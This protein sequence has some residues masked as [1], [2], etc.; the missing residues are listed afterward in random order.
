MKFGRIELSHVLT[1]NLTPRVKYYVCNKQKRKFLQS[2]ICRFTHS[3]RIHNVDN[4]YFDDLCFY[5]L[6]SYEVTP[7]SNIRISLYHFNASSYD[8]YEI[9][10]Q[11][12]KIQLQMEQR[13]IL[14]ILKKITGDECIYYSLLKIEP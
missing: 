3:T 4:A 5:K 13:A 7:H 10:P 9:N 14:L 12:H 6:F 1:E 2:C 8:F 11:K